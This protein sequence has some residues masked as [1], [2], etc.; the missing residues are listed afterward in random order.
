MPASK[1]TC[2]L[3]SSSMTGRLITPGFS[4]IGAIPVLAA[5]MP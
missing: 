4:G 3:P 2:G 5:A 1:P